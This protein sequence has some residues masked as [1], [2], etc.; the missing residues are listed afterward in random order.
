[1]TVLDKYFQLSDLAMDS[2]NYF[3][4]LIGLFDKDAI[5]KSARGEKVS[6][7]ESIRKF[8]RDFF[9]RNSALKHVWN[10]EEHDN[11]PFLKTHWIACGRRK[12]GEIFFL[13]GHDIA[14]I[15]TKNKMINLEIIIESVM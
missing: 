7:Q 9:S 3:E 4:E 6:G 5:L 11:S 8:F 12:S 10:T 2:E 1:M 13:K 15:N 14:E